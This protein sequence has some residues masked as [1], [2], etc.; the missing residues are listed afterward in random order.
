MKNI[1]SENLEIIRQQIAPFNPAIIAVTKYSDAQGIMT[2]YKADLR[3]FA[4]SRVM[5]AIQKINDLPND[6]RKNSRFHLIGHLQTN[7]VKKAVTTFDLIHSV[8]SLRLAQAISDEA[9]TLGKTQKILLQV[10]NA[11]E[12]QK[13]GFTKQDLFSQ[14]AQIYNLPAI[15]ILG[16]MNMTPLNCTQSECANLFKDLAEIKTK[17]E[18]THNIKL[19]ELSMGMSSDYIQAA[20]AGATMLRIGSKLFCKD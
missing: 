15:Q 4:E 12:P 13:H 8:D 3:D 1:I 11:N 17:L 16:L 7:K 18:N 10:N 19:P 2:A 9:Q 5:E 6:I 20:N 14:F